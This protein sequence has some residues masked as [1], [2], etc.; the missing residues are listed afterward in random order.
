M[1]LEEGQSEAQ[2]RAPLVS[3]KSRDP[4]CAIHHLE[5]KCDI[6]IVGTV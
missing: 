5:L 2:G 1:W 6:V 4:M 3:G